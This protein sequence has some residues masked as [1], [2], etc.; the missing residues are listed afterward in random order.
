MR[1][2]HA[3]ALV[4]VVG[5]I[6]AVTVARFAALLTE[7]VDAG[8]PRVIVDMAGVDFINAA[9]LTALIVAAERLR[10]DGAWL[11]VRLV[12]PAIYRLFTVT[13]LTEILGV[14]LPSPVSLFVG[15]VAGVATIPF[16]RDVLNAALKLVVTMAQAVVSGADGVSITLPQ[17]GQLATVAASNQV[18]LEMDHDQYDTGEGPCLD[19]ANRGERFRIDSLDTDT[20]WPSFIP[21]ARA[22]GIASILSTP[23]V[24]ADRPLG[25]LNIYSRTAGAFAEHE[26][27]WADQ[28]AA[29]AA[30]VVSAADLSGSTDLRADIRQ[31]LLSRQVIA[32]AQGA[33]S[34]RDGVSLTRAYADLREISRRSGLPLVEVCDELMAQISD[35]AFVRAL[36]A[37]AGPDLWPS[38]RTAIGP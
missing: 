22:R 36:P 20:R 7:A 21:R 30:R 16:T 28:F 17:A 1:I 11:T 35:D 26:L 32:Q 5:E 25:A 31:A 8:V 38:Q 15:Q 3:H 24:A 4:A 27:A 2:D 34:Q 10:V 29:E 12:S 33:V 14:E 6:D 13:G 37:A 18:V 23:L 19:A 9:G